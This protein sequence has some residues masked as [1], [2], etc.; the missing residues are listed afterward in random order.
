MLLDSSNFM[1]IKQEAQLPQTDCETHYVSWNLVKCCT[2]GVL[3][4]SLMPKNR[5][6]VAIEYNHMWPI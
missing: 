2:V 3:P 6:I 1:R 5:D 4:R